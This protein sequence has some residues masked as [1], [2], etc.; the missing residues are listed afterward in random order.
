MAF[1]SLNGSSR[2][3]A[4]IN[5]ISESVFRGLCLQLGTSQE[6]AIRRETRDLKE[7]FYER[8]STTT[9]VTRMLSGS[10]REGFRLKG[11]DQDVMW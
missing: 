6:V 10:S 9:G 8:L 4:G 1:S 11:S 3:K 5:H 2:V 7:I